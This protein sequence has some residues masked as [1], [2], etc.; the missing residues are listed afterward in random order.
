MFTY[1]SY[2]YLVPSVG[3]KKNMLF[4]INIKHIIYNN[5]NTILLDNIFLLFNSIIVHNIFNENNLSIS[6]DFSLL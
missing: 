2:E 3:S 5:S 1:V 6:N 4:N